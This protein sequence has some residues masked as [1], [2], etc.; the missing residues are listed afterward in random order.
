VF[1]RTKFLILNNTESWN[2]LFLNEINILKNQVLVS[3]KCIP[4]K[5]KFCSVICVIVFRRPI[6]SKKVTMTQV[7]CKEKTKFTLKQSGPKVYYSFWFKY[8]LRLCAFSFWYSSPLFCL[9]FS[10]KYL[11]IVDS[12]FC[13]TCKGLNKYKSKKWKKKYLF[14]FWKKAP[15]YIFLVSRNPQVCRRK[16]SDDFCASALFQKV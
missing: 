15:S 14:L 13:F 5:I 11:F 16:Q 8:R 12:G 10:C 9:H 2:H 3:V 6:M 4:L 7:T 1:R